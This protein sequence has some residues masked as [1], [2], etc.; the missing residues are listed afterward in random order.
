MLDTGP[1]VAWFNRR[2]Q[3]H[4]T[5]ASFFLEHAG[6]FVS[7]WP[8]L[9]EVCHL[10]PAEVAPRFLGCVSL[11]GLSFAFLGGSALELM[12]SWMRQY[13]D[14]L[15]DLADASL[16]WLAHEHGLR[17]IATLDRRDFGV[18]RLPGGD[19]LEN[20]LES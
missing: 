5:C 4:D 17:R 9:T 16:L 1:L 19:G 6:A 8:V 11:G 14:L 15:M 13:G 18:Y 3:D 10:I 20:L 12:A 7:T 2:D